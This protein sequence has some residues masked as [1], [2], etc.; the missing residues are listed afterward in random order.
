MCFGRRADQN[1]DS[2]GVRGELSEFID[3]FAEAAPADEAGRE[4]PGLASWVRAFSVEQVKSPGVGPQ[5]R[6][7]AGAS[8][9]EWTVYTPP[10]HPLAVP[11]RSALRNAGVGDGVLLCLPPV[12]EEHLELF[13]EAGRA[14]AAATGATRFVVVQHRLGASGLARTL[15]LENPAV[16]TTVVNLAD[17]VPGGSPEVRVAVARV[18]NETAATTGYREVRYDESGGRSVPRLR[19]LVPADPG[20]SPLTAAD[21]LLVTGGGKGITA[22]CALAIATDSGAKLA[23]LGRS[24]P[25]QDSELATN[26]SRM[27]AAGIRY[28]YQRADVTSPEQVGA[29]V[30]RLQAELGLTTAL[31]HGAGRN[32][33]T[34]LGRLTEE[35]FEQTLA[36]KVSGLRTV[37]DALDQDRIKLLI[38]FGSLIGRAGSRGEAHYAT[39]NDWLN[40]L[41][42]RFQQDHPQARAVALE[43]SVWSGAGMGERLGDVEALMREGVTPIST[44]DGIAVLR[45]VLANP[46]IGPVL[47]VT[48]RGRAVPAAAD[49]P[50]GRGVAGG[51][52]TRHDRTGPVVRA[53]PATRSPDG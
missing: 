28:R 26:L 42:V 11:L 21:V 33:P 6:V 53:L 4:V 30:D 17:P 45:Q 15:H 18:V 47:V 39:A 12:G 43:W 41:T 22:E 52:R 8:V 32:E 38:T 46:G 25:A 14:A 5:H 49:V 51:G 20:P 13:L 10:D 3:E 23:L 19:P 1:L 50:A 2:Q 16:R 40:E 9:H 48:G 34:T 27:D 35:V 37:L 7:D 31:L 36:P 44:E 29:A 24:D